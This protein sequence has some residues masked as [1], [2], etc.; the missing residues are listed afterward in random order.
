MQHEVLG[1]RPCGASNPRVY[2]YNHLNA[3]EIKAEAAARALDVAKWLFPQGKRRGQEWLAGDSKGAPGTSFGINVDSKPGVWKDFATSEKGGSNFIDLI[4]RSKGLPFVDA[5]EHLA[6]FLNVRFERIDSK[7]ITSARPRPTKTKLPS[8]S[9]RLPEFPWDDAVNRGTEELLTKLAA[10]RKLTVSFLT[11]ALGKRIFGFVP[12]R[13]RGLHVAFPVHDRSGR[14][15]AA[16]VKVPKDGAEEP[17]WTYLYDGK[18][19]P[20]TQPLIIGNVK[21]A[22]AVWVF[23]SQWDALHVMDR[24]GVHSSDDWES[25]F[26]VF[27]TRGAG[28]GGLLAQVAQER[29]TLVLWPQNDTPKEN[30]KIPSEDWVAKCLEAAGKCAVR[31]VE[32]PTEFEDPDAW[33]K[34]GNPSAAEV[35]HAVDRARACDARSIEAESLGAMLAVRRFDPMRP[36]PVAVPRFSIG[37][38]VIATPGNLVGIQAQ[39]KAGKTSLLGAMYAATMN[40]TGDCFNIN[41]D[42]S[43]GWGLIHFD[44]EQSPADHHACLMTA[45]RRAGRV[46][47]P[48]WLY[49]YRLAD[50]SLAERRKAIGFVIRRTAEECGGI[51]SVFLDGLADF[52]A[53]PNDDMEAFAFIEELHGYAIKL[54]TVIVCV[55]HENPGGVDTGKTRG[56]LGSQLERK[57]ETNLRLVKESEI[58]TVFSEKARHAYIPKDRGPRFQWSVEANMHVSVV[59]GLEEKMVSK[60]EAMLDCVKVIFETVQ[61]HIGLS[62]TQ[63]HDQIERVEGVKRETA[64]KRFTAMVQ[65][66]VIRKGAGHGGDRY[67]LG[68]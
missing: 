1:V 53:S 27:I 20:G 10:E 61:S 16:H 34:V 32:V 48:H 21:K 36:P 55:I 29:N 2:H 62:W 45:L 50:V 60:R 65:A 37:E 57:A 38:S 19:G 56:H 3:D 40:R 59:S 30:G 11:W 17:V 12:Y 33:I 64:R 43:K 54:D 9:K 58:T 31:R 23:E 68:S 63:V 22:N 14:V 42:N 66:G 25:R 39:V 8:A 4:M 18:S 28:N 5:C 67:L 35:Q 7:P 52:T 44:T 47:A 26:A 51:H 13:G 6:G 15:V 46:A 49:S 41:S 24:L